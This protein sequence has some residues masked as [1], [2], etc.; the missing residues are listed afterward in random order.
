M[1]ALLMH[2]LHKYVRPYGT[3]RE[4]LLT[5]AIVAVCTG[6]VW[7]SRT[8]GLSDANGAMFYLAAVAFVAARFGHAPAIF[9]TTLS[10]LSFPFF[11]HPPIFRFTTG[12]TQYLV[13]LA[14]LLAIGLLISE[15]TARLKSQLRS[16]QQREHR[17]A[18]LYEL[19]LQL[20]ELA[21]ADALVERAGQY[22]RATLDCEL[23]IAPACAQQGTRWF[24][25]DPTIA[26]DPDHEKITALVAS[27][28]VPA[29]FS[30]AHFEQSSVFYV[31]L[32]GAEQT[33]GIVAARYADKSPLANPDDRQTLA[34]CANLLALSIERS[35]SRSDAQAAQVQV[36]AEQ[37]RNA[38]LSSVSHDLRTPLATISVS[39]S[40]VLQMQA[41]HLDSQQRD[42]LEVVVNES[43][44]LARQVD[45]LLEMAQ[46]TSGAIVLKRDWHV[47]EELVGIA[48]TQ[49]RQELRQFQLR[50]NIPDEFPMLWVADDLFVKMMVNMLDN[51]V[52][53][54]PAGCRIEV[55]AV[56][57]D[58][59][60]TLRIADNGPGLPAAIA[61]REFDRFV[62]GSSVVADGRRGIGLGLAICRSI[63]ELHQGHISCGSR[64]GGGAEFT[65]VLPR[66]VDEASADADDSLAIN[67]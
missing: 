37:I 11:F 16:A 52:R 59:E 57:C 45:N 54:C 29:G 5:L 65:I 17:T 22:I 34:T 33:L 44:R 31:P 25:S 48:V 55:E 66:F 32:I 27:K 36:H 30:T 47:L 7:L 42:N 58:N 56:A 35:R 50:V 53:Y 39:A 62:R 40:S 41:D 12:D 1:L 64:Q 67:K 26:A 8:A 10:V 4:Y 19:T 18:Q 9:A 43:A 61:G 51:A 6:I 2:P 21:G 20:N 49:L 23:L 24:E 38:L 46:L 14:V 60:I 15:L 28:G 63:L 3:A 13:M